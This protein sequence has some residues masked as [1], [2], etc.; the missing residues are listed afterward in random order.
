MKKLLSILIS[1]LAVFVLCSCASNKDE[2]DNLS[3]YRPMVFVNDSLYGETGE[4]LLELPSGADNIGSILKKTSQDEPMV[5]ENFYS[6]S[7]PVGSEIYYDKES[8]EIIYVKVG[9]SENEMYS[10]YET[11]D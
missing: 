2:A 11:I 4:T 7:C 1:L 9:S 3:D 6:N 5:N 8:P 10:V